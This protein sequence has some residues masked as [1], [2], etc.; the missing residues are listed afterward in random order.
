MSKKK[1]IIIASASLV[2]I[3]IIVSIIF[4]YQK[5]KTNQ[6]NNLNKNGQVFTP[7]FL[8]TAEKAKLNI[9]T[10][11][12]IQ[13]VTRDSKGVVKVYRIIRSDSDIVDP[14]KVGPISPHAK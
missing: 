7:D 14:A 4:I 1:I 6:A 11:A 10:D 13:A 8:S 2:L 9:P 5:N 3:L 12:K